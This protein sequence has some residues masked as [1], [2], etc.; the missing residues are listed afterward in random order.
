MVLHQNLLNIFCHVALATGN[1]HFVQTHIYM[2]IVLCQ[3]RS[4]KCDNDVTFNNLT[5]N[6][7]NDLLY[8]DF[9]NNFDL[10]QTSRNKK[11]KKFVTVFVNIWRVFAWA[12]PLVSDQW[13]CLTLDPSHTRWAQLR[14]KLKKYMYFKLLLPILCENCNVFLMYKRIHFIHQCYSEYVQKLLEVI[15]MIKRIWNILIKFGT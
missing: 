15:W 8:C 6:V 5:P 13:S 14:S 3:C 9:S 12:V 10:F 11:C 4:F 7:L 2:V 1:F